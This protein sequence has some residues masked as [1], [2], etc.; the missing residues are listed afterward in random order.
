M[1]GFSDTCLSK[2]K[3]S[4]RLASTPGGMRGRCPPCFSPTTWWAGGRCTALTPGT[5]CP[6][7]GTRALKNSLCP[8]WTSLGK[9]VQ[10]TPPTLLGKA[11]QLTPPA[12]FFGKGFVGKGCTAY[13]P[14][15]VANFVGKGCTAYAPNGFLLWDKGWCH[16]AFHPHLVGGGQV[17]LQTLPEA[18]V[19]GYAYET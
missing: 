7:T 10:L 19:A 9:V 1:L 6:G 5:V 18:T 4:P 3:R 17:M 14:N 11:V 2:H 8:H 12:D 15:F 13:T 16:L